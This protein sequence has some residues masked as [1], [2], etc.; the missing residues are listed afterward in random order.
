MAAPPWL[1]QLL[2]RALPNHCKAQIQWHARISR[3][4]NAFLCQSRCQIFRI[5]RALL[6]RIQ[7][8][9]K[10]VESAEISRLSLH[11]LEPGHFDPDA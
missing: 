1:A 10:G 3:L 5:R 2:P 4:A 8:P 7:L 11:L 9:I 6:L